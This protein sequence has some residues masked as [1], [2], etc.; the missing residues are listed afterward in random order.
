M[1]K[2]QIVDK[3]IFEIVFLKNFFGKYFF[4]IVFKNNF[5]YFFLKKVVSN[6]A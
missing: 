1:N 4:E 3:K 2:F 6:V 5:K